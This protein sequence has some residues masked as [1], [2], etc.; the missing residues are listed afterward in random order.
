MSINFIFKHIFVFDSFSF[1][2]R[3]ER[4]DV[5]KSGPL[6]WDLS[7]WSHL[8]QPPT[9]KYCHKHKTILSVT[10]PTSL[11][12]SDRW[13]QS[14]TYKPEIFRIPFKITFHSILVLII[15]C[16]GSSGMLH[17]VCITMV[18]SWPGRFRFENDDTFIPLMQQ[19][20][21]SWVRRSA[22][23]VSVS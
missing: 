1:L 4:T 23:T 14:V 15:E 10:S 13:L 2:V 21:K 6:V 17:T 8:I 3:V 16:G 19:F 20:D 9:S 11:Y 22:L 5:V 12:N 7:W 18:N